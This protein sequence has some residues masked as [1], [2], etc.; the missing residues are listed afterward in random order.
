MGLQAAPRVRRLALL[1]PTGLTPERGPSLLGRTGLE[2]AGRSGAFELLYYRLTRRASLRDF[3]ERQVFLDAAAIPTS[4]VDYAYTTSHVKGAPHAPRHF[5][6]GSLFLPD[7]ASEIYGRLYRPT[8]LLT[9]ETPGPTVQQF[10]LLSTVLDQ[11]DHALTHETVPGGLMPHW[12]APTACFETLMPFL[13][14]E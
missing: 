2:L 5:V 9:P 1:S 14:S 6:D 11:N 12:E 8:L 13:T 3:Y 4:L 7:V 10:D